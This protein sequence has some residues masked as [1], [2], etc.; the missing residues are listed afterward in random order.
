MNRD[1]SHLHTIAAKSERRIIGLMSG[2]S[3]DGLDIALCRI[4]G[5]GI[6]TQFELEKFCT[7]GYTDEFK[8]QVRS[9]FSRRQVDLQHVC[10]MNEKIGLEHGRIVLDCLHGWRVKPQSIDLIASHGQTI[11]HAPKWRH[12]QAGF[13]SGTL[14]IG[15][16][17]HIAVTTGITTCSDFR[18]KHLAAGGEGA[19]LV[20]YGD[21]FLFASSE[22]NR[23]LLNLGGIA[24]ITFLPAAAQPAQVMGTDVGPG[25]TIMDAF[26]QRHYND[27][28]FDKDSAIARRGKV[29][30]QL[31][32]ALCE[33]SFFDAP[34]P[35]TTGPELFN[36]DYLSAALKSSSTENLALEDK[37][38]T[39]NRF[40]AVSIVR[41]I[42]SLTAGQTGFRIY[43]S[44]GGIHNGLLMEN[45]RRAMQ[46]YPVE[47]T[48]LLGVDPD[49]KEAI[50]FAI[51]A[52]ECVAGSATLFGSQSTDI[53]ATTLGKISFPS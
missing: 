29:S 18:Q 53:H 22:E 28:S 50:L 51:L 26:V 30:D 10:L 43:S 39:L 8:S 49:A 33:H 15:D 19:P 11:Y 52:N 7:I 6:E 24:N 46:Q 44:G 32:T 20:V 12:G 37:L 48:D 31:L 13:P 14:Q 23:I 47:S 17:D 27:L 41:A 35:K 5:S 1:I 9:I 40:S 2:T 34:F 38:A 3:L 45:I 25:N 42:M 16:G 4:S 21:Y 36:L